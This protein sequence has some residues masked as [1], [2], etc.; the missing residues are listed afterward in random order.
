MDIRSRLFEISNIARNFERDRRWEAL[1][2][3]WFGQDSGKNS[4]RDPHAPRSL[5]ASHDADTSTRVGS[6]GPEYGGE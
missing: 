2:R 4:G 1:S 5:D 3:Q 6:N